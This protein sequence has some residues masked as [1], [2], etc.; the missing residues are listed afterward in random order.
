MMN[1]CAEVDERD[2]VRSSDMLGTRSL[3]PILAKR[4]IVRGRERYRFLPVRTEVLG[5]VGGE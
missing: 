4:T 5:S 2:L 1:V 3:V